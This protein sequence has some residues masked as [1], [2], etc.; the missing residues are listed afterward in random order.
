[1]YKKTEE[2]GS[3]LLVGNSRLMAHLQRLTERLS[4][5]EGLQVQTLRKLEGL[6]YRLGRKIYY[7]SYHLFQVFDGLILF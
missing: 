4:S 6:D 2:G 7:F 5:I 3:S 1:M